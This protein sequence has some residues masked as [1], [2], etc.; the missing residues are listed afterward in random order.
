M[1]IS[2]KHSTLFADPPGV[3]ELLQRCRLGE[4]AALGEFYRLYRNDV[5]RTLTRV[6]GPGRP[7]LEDVLQDVFIEAFRSL[8]RFRVV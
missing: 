5:A 1:S 3:P 4:R 8:A 2:G 6:L 7:D